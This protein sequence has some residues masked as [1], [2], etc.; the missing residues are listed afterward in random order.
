VLSLG[1]AFSGRMVRFGV[2]T[3]PRG[4]VTHRTEN[5]DIVT[6]PMGFCLARLKARSVPVHVDPFGLP[7]PGQIH[8]ATFARPR[9][10]T[11]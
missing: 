1:P 11:D 8:P 5:H 9:R 3:F 6:V 2:E 10:G 7:F 4:G